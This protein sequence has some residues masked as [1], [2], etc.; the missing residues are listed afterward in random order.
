M[1]QTTARRKMLKHWWRQNQDILDARP[2]R[3][4]AIVRTRY[5]KILL[6]R[7][8]P[9]EAMK[10]LNTRALLFRTCLVVKP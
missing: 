4:D 5:R 3:Y 8:F 9:V 7:G 2:S 10:G 6:R 1:D